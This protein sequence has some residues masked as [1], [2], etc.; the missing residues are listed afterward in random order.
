V[1]RDLGTKA[2]KKQLQE[3]CNTYG[4]SLL[5]RGRTTREEINATW[6]GSE[7]NPGKGVWSWVRCY[8]DLRALLSRLS[9]EEKEA[10]ESARQ[11]QILDA[12]SDTP[13]ALTL[14]DGR[15]VN[16]YPK[17]DIA[18]IEVDGINRELAHIADHTDVLRLVD[19]PE[20][21]ELCLRAYREVSYLRRLISWIITTPG[22]GLPYPEQAET[23]VVP[24]EW[25]GAAT[26]DYY[27]LADAFQRVN[28]RRLAA[29][30]ESR[31]PEKRPS[32]PVYW[33]SVEADSGVPVAR[34]RRD[35]SLASLLATN[36]TR[37]RA[38]RE[39]QEESAPKP[40]MPPIRSATLRSA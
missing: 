10:A 26:L 24:E 12:M 25:D 32:W 1:P 40:D 35:R 19:S 33:S 20:S 18:L 8:G 29:L 21:I 23:P 7:G 9:P 6:P 17:S 15:T 11:Q 38:Q 31:A 36:A 22:A 28:V 4:K 16:V 30:H 14:S 2:L 37:A 13:E 27:L 5:V 39:A 34:L 3:T